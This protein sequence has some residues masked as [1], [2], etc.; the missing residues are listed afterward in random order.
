MCAA[1][2]SVVTIRDLFFG[3]SGSACQGSVESVCLGDV[4]GH[5]GGH[6][7]HLCPLKFAEW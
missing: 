6:I 1:D 2:K 7:E 5:G 4:H 3:G